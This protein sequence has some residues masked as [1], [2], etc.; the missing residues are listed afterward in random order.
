[1]EENVRYFG[2]LFQA[3]ILAVE[4]VK[5]TFADNLPIIIRFRNQPE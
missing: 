4:E 5:I 1:M 3:V 2:C